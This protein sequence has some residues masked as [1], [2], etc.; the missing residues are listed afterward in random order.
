M[1][2]RFSIRNFLSFLDEVELSMLPS[3]STAFPENVYRVGGRSEYSVLKSA[4]FY[5][6]NASGKSN[7]I[8]ALG[9]LQELV[10]VSPV[11]SQTGLPYQ[12]FKPQK[13]AKTTQFEVEFKQNGK[14]FAYGVVFDRERIVEEWLYRTGKESE[15]PIF[16]RK[17]DGR[18]VFSTLNAQHADDLEK[19]LNLMLAASKPFLRQAAESHLWE[20]IAGLEALREAYT[21]FSEKLVVI[22]PSAL[23]TP[24]GLLLTDQ[25]F[26]NDFSEI[27]SAFDT[28]VKGIVSKKIRV[29]AGVIPDD[30]RNNVARNEIGF[31]GNEAERL[32]VVKNKDTGELDVHKLQTI[33]GGESS[34]GCLFD[35]SEESDGTLRLFDLIP[36]LVDLFREE[37]VYVVDEIERSLHPEITTRLFELLHEKTA[38][39]AVQLIATTHETELMTVELFRKDQ[40]WFTQK[41][42]GGQT[43]LTALDQ[44]IQRNDMDIRRG[45]LLGRFG[46][47]PIIADLS[48]GPVEGVGHAE[49]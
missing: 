2:I 49:D 42:E 46:A 16:E 21:W 33:H 11:S 17:E 3:K 38:G 32:I 14:D 36:A 39:R 20:K 25:A 5:G 31:F 34:G 10:V 28:G 6:P 1:L 19:S 29:D 22:Y 35:L 45:Y 37:R 43:T 24:L 26:R 27:L 9:A 4:L 48:D 7:L 15:S 8:K 30:V 23:C 40:F 12:P 44:Y 41:T 47:L 13:E 18:I